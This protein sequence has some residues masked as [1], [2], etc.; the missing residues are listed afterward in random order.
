MVDGDCT[1]QYGSLDQTVDTTRDISFKSETKTGDTSE[2]KG[3]K[4]KT[5]DAAKVE[6]GTGARG[7][8]VRADLLIPFFNSH[9]HPVV[10][11]ATGPPVLVLTE[12]LIAC[13]TV[14]GA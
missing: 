10:G 11:T 7:K 13:L 5:I 2:E 6:L 9:T 3:L 4:R 1:Q 8:L 12:A 14:E